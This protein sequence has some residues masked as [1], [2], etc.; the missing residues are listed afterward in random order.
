MT[1]KERQERSKEMIYQAALEEFGTC[2]YDRANMEHICGKHGISKGMMYHYY[3][4]KDEL[5][6]LCV[7]RTLSDLKACIER[8]VGILEDRPAQEAIRDY[9]MIREYFFQLHPKQ[10]VI[11][12]NVLLHPPV[13][14]KS[15]LQVLR[16]P[17]QEM[18]RQFLSK[19]IE[20]MPLRPELDRKKVSRYIEAVES[21]FWN[22]MSYY[23]DEKSK[24]DLHSILE[25]TGELLN[26]FLFGIL[27]QT[28]EG[29]RNEGN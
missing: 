17:L 25:I 1:Q 12:E 22:I 18:N 14:L 6:L 13:H 10:K 29:E 23:Q 8:D 26:M 7:E 24:Q 20:Q 9:F 5:F 15:Q 11:F 19:R 2:G 21:L 3:S 4:N 16:A 27:Q 28:N